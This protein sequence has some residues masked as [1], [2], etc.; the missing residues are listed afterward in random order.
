MKKTMHCLSLTLL[1]TIGNFGLAMEQQAPTQP[2]TTLSQV[3]DNQGFSRAQHQ[4][5]ITG[6]SGIIDRASIA[7]QYLALPL[8]LAMHE[9]PI[10]T[11]VN[12][13]TI[14]KAALLNGFLVCTA[15]WIKG[16]SIST[17]PEHYN[18]QEQW[19]HYIGRKL[20]NGTVHTANLGIN[21][22]ILIGAGLTT[23]KILGLDPKK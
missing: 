10:A 7:A 17:Y 20:I 2:N 19:P 18:Q 5:S 9:A 4:E 16:G 6:I 1:A 14:F 21:Y 22:G 3:V 23:L 12:A 11:P 13:E 15:N 8:A